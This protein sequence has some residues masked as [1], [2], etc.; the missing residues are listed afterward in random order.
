LSPWRL[1]IGVFA[2]ENRLSRDFT[3]TV[4]FHPFITPVG[5]QI[6]GIGIVFQIIFSLYGEKILQLW[7][8]FYDV[9]PLKQFPP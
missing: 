2:E 1:S 8:I 3:F 9:L 4:P 7:I 5:K 6:P